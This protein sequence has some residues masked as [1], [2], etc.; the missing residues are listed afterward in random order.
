[1]QS[2]W[3]EGCRE[4]LDDS[5][6][7][8]LEETFQHSLELQILLNIVTTHT[9][10]DIQKRKQCHCWWDG[11]LCWRQRYLTTAS[12][13]VCQQLSVFLFL[14]PLCWDT[15]CMFSI[16][17]APVSPWTLLLIVVTFCL[18]IAVHVMSSAGVVSH[19]RLHVNWCNAPMILCLQSCW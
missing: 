18:S 11:L 9:H 13:N 6:L 17:L 15:G 2:S 7:Q 3:Q 4:L 8:C 14:F 19:V 10:P 12:L 5:T 16:S 1:M